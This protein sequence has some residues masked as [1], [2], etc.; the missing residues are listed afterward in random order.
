MVSTHFVEVR[1]NT[2]A[3][4]VDVAP[5]NERKCVQFIDNTK[6]IVT[7]KRATFSPCF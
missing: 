3:V 4:A 2:E 6:G 5:N 7:I 1:T